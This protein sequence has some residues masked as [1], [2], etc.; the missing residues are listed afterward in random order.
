MTDYTKDAEEFLKD[1]FCKNETDKQNWDAMK[2]ELEPSIRTLVQHID[3]SIKLGYTK[4][5]ILSLYAYQSKR[6]DEQINKAINDTRSSGN[7]NPTN[8]Y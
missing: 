3:S 4:E 5:K 6:I 8:N 7:T 1:L 2:E